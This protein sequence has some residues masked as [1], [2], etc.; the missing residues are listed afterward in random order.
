MKKVKFEIIKPWI[1]S[2]IAGILGFE[3]EVL[4]GYVFS[5]LEEKVK[6]Q[7]FPFGRNL[8]EFCFFHKYPFS[9]SICILA[10][11]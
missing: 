4:I 7:P 11:P 2:K 5:L 6:L 9:F 3:D 10:K 8:S 1:S